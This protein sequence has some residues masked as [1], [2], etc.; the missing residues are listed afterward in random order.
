M[1]KAIAR[2]HSI[3]TEIVRHIQQNLLG[4]GLIGHGP[5]WDTVLKEVQKFL[6][7]TV[8]HGFS[9]FQRLKKNA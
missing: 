1:L 8:L 7:Y 3:A 2:L 9:F 5:R 4:H 6:G